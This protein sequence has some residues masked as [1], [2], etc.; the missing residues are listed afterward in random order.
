MSDS[1]GRR[2][3][4][5]R[6]EHIAESLKILVYEEVREPAARAFACSSASQG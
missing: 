2:P 1:N 5:D 6:P 3:P 4:P